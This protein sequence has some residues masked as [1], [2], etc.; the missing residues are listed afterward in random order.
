MF[1]FATNYVDPTR[2]NTSTGDSVE[3]GQSPSGG[4]DTFDFYVPSD[5]TTSSRLFGNGAQI[6][7]KFIHIHTIKT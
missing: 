6:L 1:G 2:S 4:T 3:V 5:P 7:L